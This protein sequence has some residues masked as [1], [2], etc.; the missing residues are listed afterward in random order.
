M[1]HVSHCL[2]FIYPLFNLH[3]DFRLFEIEPLTKSCFGFRND[4]NPKTCS[5]LA[6]MG[7]LIHA[8]RIIETFDTCLSLL[9]IDDEI[10]T[11][12]L[13]D[14]GSRH[15]K[16]G[17]R[18][19]YVRLM[20]DALLFALA[21]VLGAS[22]WTSEVEKA[23]IVF[24]EAISV[25]VIRGIEQHEQKGSKHV[26]SRSAKPPSGKHRRPK[27]DA[28][29][30][31]AEISHESCDTFPPVD[32]EDTKS[33]RV[34][35]LTMKISA[36]DVVKASR[37][38]SSTSTCSSNSSSSSRIPSNGSED[39]RRGS[40]AFHLS[41]MK[42]SFTGSSEDGSVASSNTRNSSKMRM[43]RRLLPKALKLKSKI[44]NGD[45]SSDN[46]ANQNILS[47]LDTVNLSED[48]FEI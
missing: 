16:H 42:G 11:T 19:S 7:M 13:L 32:E 37:R 26:G 5:G 45:S 30:S 39:P 33:V 22:A 46:G 6:R 44:K 47:I 34:E 8:K 36:S 43:N 10:L 1:F 29:V 25:D 14:A 40:L 24:Y 48:P 9:G 17:V 41:K 28:S 12:L 21:E 18:A 27:E 2:I 38:S 23:W 3:L 15:F 35:C 31:T 20:C 4:L